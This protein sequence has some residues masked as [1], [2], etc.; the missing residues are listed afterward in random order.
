MRRTP[1]LG[2]HFLKHAWAAAKLAHAVEVQPGD[3]IVEIGP[4]KGVLTRELLARGPVVAIEKDEALVRI[5][6]ETFSEEITAG[7]LKII[8]GDIRDA[9]PETLGVDAYIV[10]AN[11][12]YYITGE[13][14]RQFLTAEKQPRAMALLIQKE[15]AQR[16]TSEKESILSLS[17]KAYGAPKII[18]KVSRTHFSPPPSVDSAILAINNI[19]KDFFT[20]IS[21]EDFFRVIHA[22]FAQKRKMLANN[23]GVVFGKEKALTAISAAG[24]DI[25]ARAENVPLE[26]WKVLTLMVTNNSLAVA[27]KF[28]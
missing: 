13:I 14:I 3:T 20:G 16:I 28:F 6:Q 24:I 5:L 18:A 4:G 2:Q 26:K 1:K 21:E 9:T 15:V 12:P 25:K 23:L 27:R 11:I 17:V 22:G 7:T 10:A 8:E 19:S